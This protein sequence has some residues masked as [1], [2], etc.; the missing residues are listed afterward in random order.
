VRIAVFGGTGRT[1]RHVVDLALAAGHDVTVFARDPAKLTIT[2]PK[3]RVVPG[4]FDAPAGIDEALRGAEAAISALGP[5]ENK[6]PY[7][8][9][10]A[11]DALIAALKRA[12]IRRLIVT[13]G[14]GVGDPSDR[15]RLPNHIIKLLLKTVARHVYNDMAGACE[16]VRASDL[17]WTIVRAPRLIDRPRSWRVRVGYVGRGVGAALSGADFADFIVKQLTDPAH[18]RKAPAISN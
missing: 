17:D 14:A 13:A 4:T 15:P 10:S 2:H 8:T 16:K 7:R 5:T 18:V 6:P 1:G 9:T 11:M 3:L 12:G